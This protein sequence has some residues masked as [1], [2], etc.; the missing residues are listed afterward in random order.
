MGQEQATL[1]QS[2]QREAREQGMRMRGD[3][4]LVAISS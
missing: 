1:Q 4:Y 3:R 2:S